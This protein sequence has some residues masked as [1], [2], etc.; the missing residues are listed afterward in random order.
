M[1]SSEVS[2]CKDDKVFLIPENTGKLNHE[3]KAKKGK[4]SE[5]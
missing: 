2:S 1:E 5:Q 3:R 4:I